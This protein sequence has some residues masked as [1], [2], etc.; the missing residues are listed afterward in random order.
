MKRGELLA[1]WFSNKGILIRTKDQDSPILIKSVEGL[2]SYVSTTNPSKRK[3]TDNIENI[4]NPAKKTADASTSNSAKQTPHQR[5]NK[6]AKT[7]NNKQAKDK[8]QPAPRFTRANSTATP[9]PNI[10]TG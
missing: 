6:S 10:N 7:S 4:D 9:S 8:I 1:G 5:T 2:A 3:A